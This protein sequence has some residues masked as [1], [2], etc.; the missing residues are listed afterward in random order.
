MSVL[1][2]LEQHSLAVLSSDDLIQASETLVYLKP[3]FVRV[4][5]MLEL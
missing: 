4:K 3:P 5:C 2:Q 1:Q